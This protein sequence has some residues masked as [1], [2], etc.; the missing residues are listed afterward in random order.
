MPFYEGLVK[1]GH[2]GARK[3]LDLPRFVQARDIIAAYE[4]LYQLPAAKKKPTAVLHVREVSY[5]EFCYGRWVEHQFLQQ[6]FWKTDI[7]DCL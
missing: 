1:M 3:Y 4:Q 6:L 5:E 7:T 2:L